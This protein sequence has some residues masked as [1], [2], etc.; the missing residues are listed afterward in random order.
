MALLIWTGGL[1]SIDGEIAY[2][3]RQGYD[4]AF[5]PWL[6]VCLGGVLTFTAGG[7]WLWV[8]HDP[9]RELPAGRGPGVVAAVQTH[10]STLVVAGFSIAGAV[11]A[12]VAVDVAILGSSLH[13][14]AVMMPL[15]LGT[16]FAGWVGANLGG[17]IG[18]RLVGLRD[19]P[20][21]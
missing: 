20:Q 9:G 18:R 7:L 2:W 17:R 13:P 5:E 4:G 6:F 1:R 12:A 21:P 14:L 15:I 3:R 8:R 16:V 11:A 10:G 19:D